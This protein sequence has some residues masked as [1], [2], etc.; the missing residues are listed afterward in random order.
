M[1]RVAPRER[2][3][4][5][6][7]FADISSFTRMSKELDPEDTHA[8]IE[9]FFK[10]ADAIIESYGGTIDKHIGDAVMGLFGAPVAHGDDPLR[11]VRAALEI[12]KAVETLSERGTHPFAVHIGVASGEVVAGGVG[13]EGRGE[14][15]VIGDSVNLAARLEQEAS[16]HE[17]LISDAV[18]RAVSGVVTCEPRTLDD[19]GDAGGPTTCWRVLGIDTERVDRPRTPIVGR[20]SELRHFGAVADSAQRLG[21]GE[22][23]LLRGEAGIGKTRL[24]EE[25]VSIAR[26]NGFRHHEAQVLDFGAGEGQDAIRVLVRS[27]LGVAVSDGSDLP[28]EA[29]AK[30]LSQN[31]VRP[32]QEAFLHDLLALPPPPRLRASYEAMDN[33]TRSE[34]KKSTISTL[35]RSFSAEAPLLIT[36]ED[37]HWAQPVTL[38]YLAALLEAIADCPIVL[39]VTTRIDGDPTAQSWQSGF[40]GVSLVAINLTPLRSA[41]S[42]RLACQFVD[43]SSK[44][45]AD[46]I[47]RADGNPL[48]LEQLLSNADEQRETSL[49]AT[50]QSL[51]LARMDRLER[52][53]RE[54]LQAAS[55]IGQRFSLDVLRHLLRRPNYDC[56]KLLEVQLVRIDGDKYRFSH[57][58]I[59]DG[60]YSSL[61]HSSVRELHRHAA[62]YF[63]DTD[64]RLCAE[65]LD[66]AQDAGAAAAYLAAARQQ[67]AIYHFVQ[68]RLLVERGLELATDQNTAFELH[69]A[70]GELL[71]FLGEVDASVAAYQQA[72]DTAPSDAGRCRALIGQVE[73]MRDGQRMEEALGLLTEAQEI[74]SKLGLIEYLAQ[75][76]CQRGN[77]FFPRG[78][79][80]ACLEEQRLSLRHAKEASSPALEARALSG[81]G[82]A[83]YAQGRMQTAHRHFSDCVTLCRSHGFAR[84]EASNLALR[85]LTHFYCG[86]PRACVEDCDRAIRAAADARQRRAELVARTAAAPAHI[87][88]LD[89]CEA[90][91]QC[92]RAMEIVEQLGARRF[93]PQCLSFLAKVMMLEGRE[94]QAA[95]NAALAVELSFETDAGR[96]FTGPWA[97]GTL[98][99]VTMDAETRAQALADGEALL[100]RGCVSHNYLWFRRDAIEAT[101]LTGDWKAAVRHA[102]AL[103]AFTASERIGWSDLYIALARCIASGASSGWSEA[104][105]NTLASL[106]AK[107][108]AAGLAMAA[109][110]AG[111]FVFTG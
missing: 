96:T 107:A 51:V 19:S 109:R 104:E 38:D 101:L 60:A 35:L 8:V 95:K 83:E 29:I 33:T 40:R 102:D 77:L 86:E 73:G 68:A 13:S 105:K 47:E 25:F 81:L 89:V 84:I 70:H 56:E 6:I 100:E 106:Q 39:V 18:F 59:R 57:S 4:V 91:S 88:M 48:F 94:T 31:R 22:A 87:E 23:I 16:S 34:G 24:V 12:H 75:I 43:R 85:G 78:Q 55:V 44:Y 17:T 37:L 28:A 98:A 64:P 42:E 10:V 74:A 27:L 61:L 3:Q 63:R 32:D 36:V 62:A 103:E 26:A 1:T 90:R 49:P 50:I 14:Y 45:V 66:K 58:L 11:A 9:S 76:H 97:L 92:H 110:L 52:P 67:Q 5:T 82:D 79:V 111:N 30:A 46:C 2:R 15:T 41:D 72:K 69:C 7:I 93:L 108:D 21:R 99:V 54:A 20:E 65:H 71:G 53:D 80:E